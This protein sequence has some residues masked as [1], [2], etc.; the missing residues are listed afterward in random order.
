MNKEEHK[1]LVEAILKKFNLKINDYSLYKVAFTHQSY[2]NE[3]NLENNQR[4]EYLGDAILGF[5]VAEFLYN[6]FTDEQEGKLTDLRK[7]YVL[8]NANTYYALDLGLDKAF[9]LGKG[10][11]DQGGR[12][13]PKLLNDLFEAFLGAVYLDSGI[14]AVKLILEEIVFSK[15]HEQINYFIDYKSRLQEHIQADDRR[16]IEYRLINSTGPAHNKTFVIGVY[17]DSIKL[18]EGTGKTKKEAEFNAAKEALNKL[19]LNN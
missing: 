4:L 2:A 5:L 16:S 14:S 11:L 9:L 12:S 13:N 8:Q 18:G 6:N 3:N 19:A 15:I 1:K 17:L 10:E 7:K